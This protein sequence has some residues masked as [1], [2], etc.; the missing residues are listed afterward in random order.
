[1]LYHTY[2]GKNDANILILTQAY[3]QAYSATNPNKKHNKTTIAASFIYLQV[4]I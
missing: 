3:T 1:M 2:Y 4:C